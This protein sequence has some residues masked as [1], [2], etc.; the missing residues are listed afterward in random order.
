M[1]ARLLRDALERVPQQ[2]R[3]HGLDSDLRAWSDR[4]AR[5]AASPQRD[6]YLQKAPEILAAGAGLASKA[7]SADGYSE[8]A[9]LLLGL[10]AGL[11]GRAAGQAV[12][13]RVVRAGAS[14]EALRGALAAAEAAGVADVEDREELRTLEAV[15]EKL[16]ADL[17]PR[18]VEWLTGVA[19]RG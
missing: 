2:S 15:V 4:L 16:T 6:P 18:A 8:V 13:E 7:R 11:Q 12:R 17:G 19:A 3:V 9:G 10:L 5:L 1:F 14:L